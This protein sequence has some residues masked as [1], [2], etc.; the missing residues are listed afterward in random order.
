MCGC[1]VSYLYLIIPISDTDGFPAAYR[2]Q[3]SS[4]NAEIR[5]V[6][7]ETSEGGN[8]RGFIYDVIG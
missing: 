6:A 4:P 5:L 2:V 8:F 7:I 3:C 1:V